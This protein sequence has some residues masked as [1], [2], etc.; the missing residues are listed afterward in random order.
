MTLHQRG[1]AEQVEQRIGRAL[2]LIEFAIADR[3]VRADDAVG[4]ADHDLWVAIGSPQAGAELA[5]EA[6]VQ[7]LELGLFGFR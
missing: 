4:R 2:D 1:I 6:V 7:A 5:R 3:A